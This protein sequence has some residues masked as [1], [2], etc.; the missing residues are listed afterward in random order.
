MTTPTAKKAASASA[1]PEPAELS[2]KR[3]LAAV[4]D[5]ADDPETIDALNK[6]LYQFGAQDPSMELP[7]SWQ[8]VQR[9][10]GVDPAKLD[11]VATAEQVGQFANRT[12]LT[13]AK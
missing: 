2:T 6:V 13:V 8:R 1:T 10:I 7:R 4:N 12:G 9:R 5:G 3:I 11:G